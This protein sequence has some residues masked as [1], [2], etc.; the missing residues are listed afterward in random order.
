MMLAEVPLSGKEINRL[1]LG[2]YDSYECVLSFRRYGLPTSVHVSR[3]TGLSM[4][5]WLAMRGS[6][7]GRL[8]CRAPRSASRDTNLRR[9]PADPHDANSVERRYFLGLDVDVIMQRLLSRKSPTEREF[10]RAELQA[11]QPCELQPVDQLTST[12]GARLL[13]RQRRYC[14]QKLREVIMAMLDRR[15]NQ[16]VSLPRR[17]R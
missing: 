13:P 12:T 15:S 17:E 4:E 14:R 6:A 7:P 8:F 9:A 11:L 5:R 2:D 16:Q 3:Q 1:E 10:V